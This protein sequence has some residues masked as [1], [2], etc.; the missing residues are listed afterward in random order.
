MD[1]GHVYPFRYERKYMTLGLA[2]HA[3]AAI[4]H[5]KM[6]EFFYLGRCD[7]YVEI[8]EYFIW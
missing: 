5:R 2:K 7:S 8:I 6:G 3:K 4:F 1:F